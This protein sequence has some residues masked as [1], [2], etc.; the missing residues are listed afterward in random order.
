MFSNTTDLLDTEINCI[1]Y[2]INVELEDFQQKKWG[3]L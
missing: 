1:A 3:Q 2:S